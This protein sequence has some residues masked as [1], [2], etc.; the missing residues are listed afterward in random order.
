MYPTVLYLRRK[1]AKRPGLLQVCDGFPQLVRRQ[2]CKPLRRRH[3][4]VT[5]Q[6]LEFALVA[7]QDIGCFHRSMTDKNPE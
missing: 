5:E 4:A 3:R 2:V 6:V 1:Y 7:K